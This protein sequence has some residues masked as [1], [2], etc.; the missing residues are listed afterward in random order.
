M[1]DW[2][3]VIRTNL[4]SAFLIARAGLSALRD[5]RGSLLLI[6]SSSARDG[7]STESG[8]AYAASKAGMNN[9]VRYLAR[10]WAPHGIRVNAIA[11][12]PVDTPMMRA[13]GAARRDAYAMASL[14]GQIADPAEIGAMAGFLLSQHARSITGAI[15]NQSGGRVL[16]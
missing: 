5:S 16:D 8:P 4:T 12:G 6:S 9:L 1:S 15:I 11:P 7:G 13:A 3:R 14:T 2:D 10:E